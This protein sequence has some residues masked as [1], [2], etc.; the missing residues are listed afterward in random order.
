MAKRKKKKKEERPSLSL[1]RPTKYEQRFCQDLIDHQSG[2]G[3]FHTFPAY[4]WHTHKVYICRRTLYEWAD[5]HVEFLH[6]KKLGADLCSMWWE[7]QGRLQM[8]RKDKNFPQSAYIF[9]MKN[10]AGWRDRVDVEHTGKDG[11]PIEVKERKERLRDIFQD[12]VLCEAAVT[13][14]KQLNDRTGNA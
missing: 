1:G 11:G 13:I 3:T 5:K 8:R 10:V 12:D 14:A 9:T 2:G 4:I 6:T 7:H